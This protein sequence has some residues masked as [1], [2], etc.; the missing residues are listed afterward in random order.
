MWVASLLAWFLG[1]NQF[2]FCF[3]FSFPQHFREYLQQALCSTTPFPTTPLRHPG[4][5]NS[6]SVYGLP[7]CSTFLSRRT[8]WRR[9][10]LIQRRVAPSAVSPSTAAMPSKSRAFPPTCA[11]VWH[12]FC[13]RKSECRVDKIKEAFVCLLFWSHFFCFCLFV[14][15]PHGSVLSSAYRRHTLGLTI[16]TMLPCARSVWSLD[17]DSPAFLHLVWKGPKN[18]FILQTFAFIVWKRLK[19]AFILETLAFSL[20]FL[21]FLVFRPFCLCRSHLRT[22]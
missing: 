6:S 9:T 12:A 14:C 16:M 18:A 10:T 20:L 4:A 21:F 11:R 19:N 22:P 2:L 17:T 3:L 5:R 1:F 13:S 7:C 15:F 8:T